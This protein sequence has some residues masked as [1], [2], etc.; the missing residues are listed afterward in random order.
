MLTV[1]RKL[2]DS[3]GQRCK[4]EAYL[5]TRGTNPNKTIF[6]QHADMQRR[7]HTLTPTRGQYITLA[8]CADKLPPYRINAGRV[9]LKTRTREGK[10]RW[11]Y[12]RGKPLSTVLYM[13]L[14]L[15]K[16]RAQFHK[17]VREKILLST[18]YFCSVNVVYQINVMWCTLA[19]SDT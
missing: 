14:V 5:S 18:K 4:C 10:G 12:L 7:K 19:H 2:W 8:V 9:F 3:G 13:E 1:G 17:V 16:S 6:R 15:W 11:V